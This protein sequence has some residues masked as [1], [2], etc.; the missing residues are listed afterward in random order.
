MFK[1]TDGEEN[2]WQS[3]SAG[4]SFHWFFSETFGA[5][6]KLSVVQS[7]GRI[8]LQCSFLSLF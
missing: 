3:L 5:R 4:V 6:E 1:V 7:Q 8:H 2:K